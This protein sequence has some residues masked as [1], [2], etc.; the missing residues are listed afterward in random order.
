LTASIDCAQNVVVLTPR[1]Q[2]AVL[3]IA[4]VAGLS[5]ALARIAVWLQTAHFAAV[6]VFPM[7]LGAAIGFSVVW[8]ARRFAVQG[9]AAMI[10]GALFAAAMVVAAE[11][12]LFYLDYRSHFST[13]IQSDP[14]AQLVLALEPDQFQPATF[15]RFM[16]AEA[17][18]KWPLWIADALAMIAVAALVAWLM[19]P[20]TTID[21]VHV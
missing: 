12:G 4:V 7:I 8:T 16:A 2:G 19:S 10:A 9:R 11:H 17:P 5:V 13:A 18:G 15:Y 3:W 6:G 21:K 20:G 1:W 14:K